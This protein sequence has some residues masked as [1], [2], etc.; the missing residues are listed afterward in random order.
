MSFVEKYGGDSRRSKGRFGV[1]HE[2][3]VNNEVIKTLPA[4]YVT[5]KFIAV[6]IRIG[7]SFL[8]KMNEVQTFPSCSF[9]HSVLTS[10]H[11]T[12]PFNSSHAAGLGAGYVRECF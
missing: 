12:D 3:T 7:S 11:C 4:F 5:R 8:W 10:V 2:I 1:A 9:N 6:L